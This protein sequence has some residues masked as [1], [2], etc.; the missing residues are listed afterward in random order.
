MVCWR[1]EVT[2]VQV[3]VYP[4]LISLPLK[5]FGNSKG[6][7]V[8]FSSSLL[9]WFPGQGAT[10]TQ[11]TNSDWF[12]GPPKLSTPRQLEPTRL[13]L[14][15]TIKGEFP[16]IERDVWTIYHFD[17]TSKM[18]FNPKIES[19]PGFFLL[20]FCVHLVCTRPIQGSYPR[21]PLCRLLQGCCHGIHSGINLWCGAPRPQPS[22]TLS[23]E[24]MKYQFE[25][26]KGNQLYKMWSL[27]FDPWKSINMF[28]FFDNDSMCFFD[29]FWGNGLSRIKMAFH[30]Y[31]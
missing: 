22:Q 11:T 14:A 28:F 12:D 31:K 5:W 4:H 17:A 8:A 21:G 3:T 1:R 15:W 20:F 30:G 13:D 10:F 25:L 18:V 9:F 7:C 24:S 19:R 6:K 16:R 23:I 26:H 27:F 2:I 29:D